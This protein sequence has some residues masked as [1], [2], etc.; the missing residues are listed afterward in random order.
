MTADFSYIASNGRMKV[1]WYILKDLEGSD[2]GLIVVVHR[3]LPGVDEEND[4]IPHSKE[5]T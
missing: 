5:P 1:E 4:E 2:G 3:H